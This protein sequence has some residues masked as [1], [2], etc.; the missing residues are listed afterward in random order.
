MGQND[1]QKYC[2]CRSTD[3]SRFMIGCDNCEEWYHGDCISIT[4]ELAKK[5]LK[6][7]CFQCRDRDPGLE[8]VFKEP[9]DRGGGRKRKQAHTSSNNKQATASN[10]KS[11][12]GYD[13]DELVVKK[14]SVKQARRPQL[15]GRQITVPPKRSHRRDTV[16]YDESAT[17]CYGPGCVKA[18]RKASK[19]CSDECGMKLAYNRIVEILPQRLRQW[20]STGSS[21]DE[22]SHKELEAIRLEMNEARK[23][24]EELDAKQKEL[25][26]MITEAKKFPAISEDEVDD[27]ETDSE[28]MTYCVTCGHE[29]ASRTAM[30]HM[31]RCFNKYES[32]TS[33]VSINKTKVEGVFCEA[34]NPQHKTFCMRLRVLCPEHTKEQKIPDDEVCGCP[35]TSNVFEHNGNFCRVPKKKCMKHYCWEKLRR[36]QLDMEKVQKWLKIEELYER[37]QKIKYTMTNRGSVLGLLLHQT[38]I[39]DRP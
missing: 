24:L 27:N 33:F 34:F 4:A 21:A 2:I 9:K 23:S 22:F 19:Y 26:A 11:N 16:D 5:M 10:N 1:E 36:A 31:E 38:I 28:L 32:Q 25:E 37:D 20:Q 3:S 15:R 6:F 8:I 17:Q 30:R 7:Y 14:E 13:D 18:A 29:V 35:L 39:E 12:K